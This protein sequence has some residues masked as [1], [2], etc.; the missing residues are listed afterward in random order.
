MEFPE[1]S[2]VSAIRSPGDWWAQ[3]EL[4]GVSLPS[5]KKIT[6]DKSHLQEETSYT[7]LI[8]HRVL[9]MRSPFI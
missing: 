6:R 3:Y 8:P 2:P 5:G 7:L 9:L 4:V 1:Q